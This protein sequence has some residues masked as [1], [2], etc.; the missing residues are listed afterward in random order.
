MIKLTGYAQAVIQDEYMLGAN[1]SRVPVTG[2]KKALIAQYLQKSVPYGVWVTSSGLEV[3]FNREYRPIL[4]RMTSTGTVRVS[5]DRWVDDIVKQS[6]FSHGIGPANATDK[7]LRN[8]LLAREAF[9]NK[10]SVAE[11]IVSG[12]ER[13]EK[14]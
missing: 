9:I 5:V 3:L 7:E 14:A 12:D 2:G 4:E 13:N 1:N 6:W 10:R 8:M 11:F